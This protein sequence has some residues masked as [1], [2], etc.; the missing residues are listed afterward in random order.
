MIVIFALVK[1]LGS[2]LCEI[3][4]SNFVVIIVFDAWMLLDTFFAVY[5]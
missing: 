2:A 5:Q 4:D 3:T 1:I